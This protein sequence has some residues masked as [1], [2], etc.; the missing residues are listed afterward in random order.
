MTGSAPDEIKR[1]YHHGSLRAAMLT[2]A[3]L[4]LERDGIQGLTLRAAAREA[5]A[6]HAAPKNHFGD[7]SGLLSDLAAVGFQ[8]FAAGQRAAAAAE[9]EPRAKLIATGQAYVAF[10]AANP[11]MFQLMFRS[12][13]L[14]PSRPTLGEAMR[15]A[16]DAFSE[17]LSGGRPVQSSEPPAFAAMARRV[18]AWSLVHG[19]AMLLLDGRLKPFLDRLPTGT[20]AM[21]LL[22]A[23]LRGGETPG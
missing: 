16:G 6:S 2:A 21:S 12:E 3:E 11:G 23:I 14:D 13:R 22:D 17:A 18:A 20:D 15:D 7:L 8:R 5:G 1:P 19:F 10:A 4:I 9:T